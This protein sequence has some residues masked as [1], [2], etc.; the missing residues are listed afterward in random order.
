PVA[1]NGVIDLATWDFKKDGSVALKG[2]WQF[3][4]KQ[5][6]IAKDLPSDPAPATSRFARLPAKWN[7][8]KIDQEN[9]GSYGYGTYTL[10]M[11]HNHAGI[12]LAFRIKEMSSAY[13]LFIDGQLISSNG[14]VGKTKEETVPEY[15]PLTVNFTPTGNQTQITLQI[16]NFN[17]KEGGP[18]KE[19]I[20]GDVQQI[21]TQSLNWQVINLIL[22]GLIFSIGLY[23]LLLYILLE[24]YVSPLYFGIFCCLISLRTALTNDR[25][26]H[27]LCPGISWDILLKLEYLTFYLAVP[28][29]V[30]YI[31][32]LFPKEFSRWLLILNNILAA[33]SSAVVIFYPPTVFSYTLNIYQ[34]FT[35]LTGCYLIRVFVQAHKAGREGT[36]V[37]F[38]GFLI[39][40]LC[41]FY[42]ILGANYVIQSDY[43]LHIGMFIFIFS[44]AYL[45]SL[46]FSKALKRVEKQK[47]EIIESHKQFQNSRIALILGLA[48][49]AE[50]RDEDTGSHLERIREYAKIL[51]IELS[52]KQEYTEYISQDY[53]NDLYQSSILHDI[54][55]IGIPDAV[56]LKPGKLTPE[57]FDIIKTHTTIGGDAIAA[58]ESNSKVRSFLTLG[59]NIA[60]SHHEKWNGQ[61]YPKGLKGHQIPLSARIVAIADVYDALTS[62]RPYKKAF[63]HEKSVEII[64]KDSSTHFD[65]DII[66]IFKKLAPQF[67]RIRK[68]YFD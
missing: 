68:N 57:E 23:H 43:T 53:I 63:S 20:V 41:V 66:E 35:I 32:S 30:L 42:D 31:A 21:H 14:K 60:Y 5:L 33:A 7:H 48:K 24:K 2:E 11:L 27:V 15:R 9:I 52:K 4:W 10:T 64:L 6:L 25:I 1:Q 62:E 55:K 58:I 45:L 40:F 19:I 12:P 29:F 59:R 49:L 37:I 17:L 28:I 8:F 44:Q 56:L 26:L 54:G 61:G 46:K 16:S 50:Y 67:Q 22:I 34:I 36:R 65:P 39:L 13:S 18:I 3:F 51:A 47:N 38:V